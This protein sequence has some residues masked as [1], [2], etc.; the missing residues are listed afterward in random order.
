[1][2]CLVKPRLDATSM[3]DDG[4]L[5]VAEQFPPVAFGGRLA[6]AIDTVTASWTIGSE[7]R[8]SP[9]YLVSGH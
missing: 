9:P 4:T 5:V 6:G 7:A 8:R 3:I 2:S 1:V